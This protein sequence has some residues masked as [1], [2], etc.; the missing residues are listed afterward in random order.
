MG[1]VDCQFGGV[2]LASVRAIVDIEAMELVR[3]F[4]ED[5]IAVFEL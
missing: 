1:L 4:T 2:N 5:Q 3:V